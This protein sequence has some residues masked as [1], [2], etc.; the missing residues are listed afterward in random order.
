MYT[1]QESHDTMHNV[2]KYDDFNVKT[3]WYHDVILIGH[4]HM[5]K[6]YSRSQEYFCLNF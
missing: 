2:K 6:L 1:Y 3:H 4:V 5:Y